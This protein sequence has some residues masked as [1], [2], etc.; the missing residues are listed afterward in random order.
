MCAHSDPGIVYAQNFANDALKDAQAPWSTCC[1]KILVPR[2]RFGGLVRLSIRYFRHYSI[3]TTNWRPE[4]R[5]HRLRSELR[6]NC[7][8]RC[9]GTLVKLLY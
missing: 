6:Q 8:Q 9:A 1:I 2:V 3:I 7:A 4:A 5:W